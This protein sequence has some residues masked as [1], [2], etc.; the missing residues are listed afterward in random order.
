MNRRAIAGWEILA[1][2]FHLVLTLVVVVALFTVPSSV[3]NSSIQPTNLD[4]LIMYKRILNSLTPTSPYLGYQ[5][6]Q[7]YFDPKQA[8]TYLPPEKKDFGVKIQAGETIY[9]NKQY[10]LDARP[11]AGVGYKNYPGKLVYVK[12]TSYPTIFIDQIYAPRYDQ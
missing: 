4:A 12:G 2:F 7:P 3:L 1:W 11:L 8:I 5:E 10:Y 6:G 9:I